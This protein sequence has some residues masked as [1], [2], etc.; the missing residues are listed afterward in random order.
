[1]HPAAVLLSGVLRETSVKG[2]SRSLGPSFIK[3]ADI[4]AARKALAELFPLHA[5]QFAK[6]AVRIEELKA[7][8]KDSDARNWKAKHARLRELI[9]R[10]PDDFAIDSRQ[11]NLVGVTHIP[12]GF[13]YHTPAHTLPFEL[14]DLEATDAPRTSRANRP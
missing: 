1:M 7:V 2:G 10:Y 5:A 6:E 14:R 3:G 4:L 8:K 12:T 13:R 9:R 11:G